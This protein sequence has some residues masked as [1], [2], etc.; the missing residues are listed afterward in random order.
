MDPSEL[1]LEVTEVILNLLLPTAEEVA[2]L[3]AYT[4]N[5]DHLDYCGQ[6]FSFFTRIEGLENR[7]IIQKIMLSWSDEAQYAL[8]VLDDVTKVISELKDAKTLEPLQEIMAVVLTVGNYMNGA[9]RTGR[10]HGFKLD[11][12]LKL[13]D[14]REKKIPQRNLLHF[15]IEQFPT[16]DSSVF[17]SHW[18]TMWKVS[19]VS[20]GNVNSIINQLRESLEVCVSAIHSAGD[21]QNEMIRENLI[22]RLGML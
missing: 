16:S 8:S 2:C 19:K 14:V 13:K 6:L 9:N 1:T 10:A 15:V 12:L 21:I 3:R 17:Y 5:V 20:K 11:T 18:D 4:G 7:L 22:L